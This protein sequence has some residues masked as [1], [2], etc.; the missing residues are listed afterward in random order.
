[1]NYTVELSLKARQEL[2]KASEWYDEKLDGLGEEFELE[3]F[4]K[5][6]LIQSNPLHYP[7]KG[8]YRETLTERFPYLIV[9]KIDQKRN[10]ILIVSVFHTSRPPKRKRKE[11]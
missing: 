5:T 8:R 6:D 1:M 11:I 4:R 9:Y 2:T 7:L 10:I 3:F